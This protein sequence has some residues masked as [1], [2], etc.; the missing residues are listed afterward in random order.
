MFNASYTGENI[1][2]GNSTA[3]AT[4]CQWLNS[5]GHR[6]NM[7]NSMHG[8]LGTGH[9]SGTNCYGSYWVQD[10]GGVSPQPGIV[11][12]SHWDSQSDPTFGALLY[13]PGAG[14]PP[15]RAVVVVD[16]IC[17]DMTLEWGD[18]EVGAYAV[19]GLA[20]GSGCHAYWFLYN[21]SN[22]DRYA[23]PTTGSFLFGSGCGGQY[24]TDQAGADCEGGSQ[25][26]NDGD[27]RACYTGPVDTRNVGEC[28]DG[29]Q[30]C[31]NGTYGPCEGQ[32]LPAT[33]ECDG[34]DNDCNGVVDDPC[35]CTPSTEIACGSAE[36][37]CEEGVQTCLSNGTYGPCE[38]G[39]GPQ[40]EICDG[41]D[42]DCDG[43]TDNA[44]VEID[45]SVAPDGQ[46]P[47]STLTDGGMTPDSASTSDASTADPD[48]PATY[49]TG[50]GCRQPAVVSPSGRPSSLWFISV[51]GMLA[52]LWLCVRRGLPRLR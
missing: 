18:D 24:T 7:C 48:D 14:G 32:T 19:A 3:Y 21:D 45:G 15:Q 4:I 49:Q 31:I 43:V 1:A 9:F 12:G 28:V 30:S 35:D 41:L 2:A 5:S 22:G 33:E 39:V 37:E 8:S 51:I 13:D 27:T 36:G 17:H 25:S 47:D 29:Q 44:C 52:G 10:F 46:T 26:C 38:G 20:P 42:N 34:L 6:S 50:C 40:P 23:Y 16:G 11:S